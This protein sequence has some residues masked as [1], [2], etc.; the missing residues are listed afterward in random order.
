MANLKSSKKDIRRTKRRTFLNNGYRI[1]FDIKKKDFLKNPDSKKIPKLFSLL[2]KMSKKNIFHKNKAAR[3][4][5]K[6]VK[7]TLKAK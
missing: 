7:M 6:F 3:L 4:K 2:D 1:D 5:S